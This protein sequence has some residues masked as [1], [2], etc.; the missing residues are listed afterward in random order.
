MIHCFIKWLWIQKYRM[1][2]PQST[3][4]RFI[5]RRNKSSFL[6]YRYWKVLMMMKESMAQEISKRIIKDPLLQKLVSLVLSKAWI[7]LMPLLLWP[8]CDIQSSQIIR[9]NSWLQKMKGNNS[10]P[11]W[12]IQSNSD[13]IELKLQILKLIMK[14]LQTRIH[15]HSETSLLKPLR[16]YSASY[17]WK[18]TQIKMIT[19]M[20]SILKFQ[21][22]NWNSK[23]Y[24]QSVIQSKSMT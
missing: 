8:S 2:D 19:T 4:M 7:S 18:I 23:T 17:H 22:P 6:R 1:K 21:V 24:N 3:K 10:R 20:N 14:K 12:L 9:A 11:Q 5:M 15:R 16:K 13:I